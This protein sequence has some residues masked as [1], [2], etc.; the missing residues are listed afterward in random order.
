[1]T[2]KVLLFIHIAAGSVALAAGTVAALAPKGRQVH[3]R[4]GV[5]FA[6]A[7]ALCALA[8]LVISLMKNNGFLLAISMFTLYLVSTGFL[9]G[10]RRQMQNLRRAL[11]PVGAVGLLF[12]AYMLWVGWQSGGQALMV[13]GTF[14]TMLAGFSV[15]DLAMPLRPASRIARHAGRMGGAF[16]AAVTAVLVVNV[17]MEPAWVLWLGPTVVGTLLL[18]VGIGRWKRKASRIA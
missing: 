9:F 5:V 3:S 2:I 12:A 17:N 11:R 8:G 7:M 4:S 14:G 10:T 13:L 18:T 16:I 6:A 15:A 1:M